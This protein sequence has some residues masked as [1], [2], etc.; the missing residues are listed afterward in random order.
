MGCVNGKWVWREESGLGREEEE[1][2]K[3]EKKN[4]KSYGQETGHSKWGPPC[5]YIYGNAIENR[6][7][8]TENN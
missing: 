3:K 2:K 6:V 4:G 1:E 8:E 5:Q 7:M